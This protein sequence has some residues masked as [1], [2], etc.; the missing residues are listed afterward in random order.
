MDPEAATLTL[1]DGRKVSGDVIIAADGI[2]SKTRDVITGD[3]T[4]LVSTG[5][6]CYRCIT[7]ISDIR[8]D[9]VTAEFVESPGTV[10]EILGEDRSIIFY[11]CSDNKSLYTGAFVPTSEVGVTREGTN[12]CGLTLMNLL[13]ANVFSFL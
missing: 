11:P 12:T 13:L 10:I 1:T 5:K 3:K 8:Q 4:E 2:H 6:S 9:P 7:P